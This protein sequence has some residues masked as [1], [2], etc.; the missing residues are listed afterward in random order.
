MTTTWTQAIEI[1]ET[2]KDVYEALIILDALRMQV[3]HLASRIL[4][5]CAA[6]PTWHVQA[7]METNGDSMQSWLPDGMR[8]VMWR[9]Y[10]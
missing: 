2:A 1:H 8:H 10:F 9:G 5:P 7:I 3:D 6:K 4:H